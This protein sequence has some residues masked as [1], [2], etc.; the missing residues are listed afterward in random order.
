MVAF[1]WHPSHC[2]LLWTSI[3]FL[4]GT[5]TPEE[6]EPPEVSLGKNGLPCLPHCL[7]P[8]PGHWEWVFLHLGL[9]LIALA[10]L[11]LTLGASSSIPY[12]HSSMSYAVVGVLITF[13]FLWGCP[14]PLALVLFST[15]AFAVAQQPSCT[16]FMVISTWAILPAQLM[17]TIKLN[18]TS[19]TFPKGNPYLHDHHPKNSI[20]SPGVRTTALVIFSSMPSWNISTNT[21][22]LHA[23]EGG[24]WSPPPPTVTLIWMQ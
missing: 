6:G 16:A 17:G 3:P 23:W 2:W 20:A 13:I 24:G 19:L 12:I 11:V 1:S 4:I 15:T 8:C 14:G 22:Q 21:E 7:L 18:L 9:Q 5:P 10:F